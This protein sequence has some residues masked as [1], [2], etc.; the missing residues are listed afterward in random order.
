[1]KRAASAGTAQTV[2]GISIAADAGGRPYTGSLR[3]QEHTLAVGGA[4]APVEAL[5]GEFS[6]VLRWRESNGQGSTALP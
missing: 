4:V 6:E 3:Y 5:D 1:M 2:I